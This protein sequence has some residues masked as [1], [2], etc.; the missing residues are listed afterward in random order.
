VALPPL[1]TSA[2]YLAGRCGGFD[3]E[4]TCGKPRGHDGPC[5][6]HATSEPFQRWI[7]VDD[8]GQ[9]V[10]R[11]P[12]TLPRWMGDS[13][14]R[15]RQHKFGAVSELVAT[16]PMHRDVCSACGLVRAS[17]VHHEAE[18][19]AGRDWQRPVAGA[20]ASPE[21]TLGGLLGPRP[22]QAVVDA[23]KAV[24]SERRVQPRPSPLTDARSRPPSCGDVL[25]AGILVG[26]PKLCA[27]ALGHGGMHRADDGAEWLRRCPAGG[28]ERCVLPAEHTGRHRA[29]GCDGCAAGCS[30]CRRCS[31][32][33]SDTCPATPDAEGKADPT[34]C[35]AI[36]DGRTAR[37]EAT[38][39]RVEAAATMRTGRKVGRTLYLTSPGCPD[40]V[41]IGVVDT[42][43]L[44]AELARRWNLAEPA[45]KPPKGRYDDDPAFLRR[46]T[47]GTA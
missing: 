14:L 28:T 4:T 17:Y 27:L 25:E 45:P 24:F 20:D 1:V 6:L 26:A 11:G 33:G 30:L 42:P 18:L 32:C 13:P 7:E 46:A 43:E 21:A 36:V 41:L 34:A 35:T 47:E 2:D 29:A 44:A 31:R 37:H 22:P 19:A 5:R 23:A 8:D 16:T 38:L 10:A 40:G 15:K 9:E 39:A 3:G 12:L